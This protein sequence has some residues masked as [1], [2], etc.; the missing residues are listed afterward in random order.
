MPAAKQANINL[1][2]DASWNVTSIT[3][4]LLYVNNNLISYKTKKQTCIARSSADAEVI[5]SADE[6]RIEAAIS[7]SCHLPTSS[8]IHHTHPSVHAP[9]C[10]QPVPTGRDRGGARAGALQEMT[11]AGEKIYYIKSKLQGKLQ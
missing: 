6:S 4:T 1:L 5:P 10:L 3:G 9:R 8:P 2:T 7:F 11:L